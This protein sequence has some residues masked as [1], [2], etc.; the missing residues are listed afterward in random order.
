[1]QP[2][3]ADVVWNLTRPASVATAIARIGA[4]TSFPWCHPCGRAAP[5]SFPYCTAPI[6]GKTIGLGTLPALEPENAAADPA[7]EARIATRRSA[8]RAVV[9][10]LWGM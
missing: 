5:K 7:V 1:M 8:A 3:R 6:T 4:M 2:A 10:W 9:R